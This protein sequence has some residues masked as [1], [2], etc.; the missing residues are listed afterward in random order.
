MAGVPKPLGE[1]THGH[2]QDPKLLSPHL[3]APS[4][5]HAG[6]AT[7][8]SPRSPLPY[9]GWGGAGGRGGAA[10]SLP[11]S[12]MRAAAV[13]NKLKP[14]QNEIVGRVPPCSCR[15]PS[16]PG[17]FQM[18]AQARR[19][20][21]QPGSGGCGGLRGARRG[22]GLVRGVEGVRKKEE[23]TP[24]AP[25]AVIVIAA[26]EVAGWGRRRELG[27]GELGGSS[28]ILAPLWSRQE[29]TFFSFFLFF[30]KQKKKAGKEKGKQEQLLPGDAAL[31][32]FLALFQSHRS[33]CRAPA[34]SHG[35]LLLRAPT[36]RVT[37]G[38]EIRGWSHPGTWGPGPELVPTLGHPRGSPR[39]KGPPCPSLLGT[40]RE[41][42]AGRGHG[43]GGRHNP[44]APTCRGPRP[45]TAALSP[46]PRTC[47]AGNL[48]RAAAGRGRRGGGS[49]VAPFLGRG[50][51]WGACTHGCFG[52]FVG[53]GAHTQ[54]L[55]VLGGYG[56][57]WVLRGCGPHVA[58]PPPSSVGTV[59]L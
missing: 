2:H 59:G 34:P 54:V 33:S 48:H 37:K 19:G 28:S 10:R 13:E 42:R 3:P 27:R 9:S 4:H 16:Q 20:C 18:S 43:G 29:E 15:L 53:G 1:P 46:P 40:G 17:I 23:G 52:C 22:T 47:R 21:R 51:P 50:A 12:F 7:P 26:V 8:G 38:L 41:G 14:T 31:A 55:W 24:A 49:L 35:H 30:S 57:P 11:L 5:R 36:V 6:A 44:A 39:G 45:P 32:F 56:H 58:P 25:A